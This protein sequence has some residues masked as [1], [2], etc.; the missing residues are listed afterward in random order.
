MK[1][2]REKWQPIEVQM[3]KT[4][5]AAVGLEGDHCFTRMYEVQS[6]CNPAKVKKIQ[7]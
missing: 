3:M 2:A 5:Q 6:P 1:E 4:L 7:H